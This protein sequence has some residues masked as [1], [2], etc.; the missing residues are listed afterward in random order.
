M[1]VNGSNRVMDSN[2][3][4]GLVVGAVAGH[5]MTRNSSNRRNEPDDG[6][7]SAFVVLCILGFL[8]MWIPS[9][10]L[11]NSNGTPDGEPSA[12]RRLID[13]RSQEDY[14]ADPWSRSSGPGG[15]AINRPFDENFRTSINE[16]LITT[17][18][19][20]WV[21]S[22]DTPSAEAAIDVLA[23]DLAMKN[24]TLWPPNGICGEQILDRGMIG[25][26]FPTNFFDSRRADYLE[27]FVAVLFLSI[28][29]AGVLG[30]PL[31][32]R[33]TRRGF[34]LGALL[35]IGTMFTLFSVEQ[36]SWNRLWI[37]VVTSALAYV[38]IIV[39]NRV[40]E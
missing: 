39:F 12:G 4:K 32:F 15:F 1:P 24:V 9:M 26:F 25:Q 23:G 13:V 17:D 34:I 37:T 2:F 19:T 35:A 40:R 30:F 8:M 28:A 31:F 16:W 5:V 18:S 3:T 22:Y 27:Q 14:R 11:S 10:M 33:M 29:W 6:L 20:V 21:C 36:L 7:G 38:M